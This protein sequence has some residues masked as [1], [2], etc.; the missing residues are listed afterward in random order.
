MKYS[1]PGTVFL[2]NLFAAFVLVASGC[3]GQNVN[4]QELLNRPIEETG[5]FHQSKKYI[6]RGMTVVYLTG[7]PYEIGFAH[8]KLCKDEIRDV[9]QYYWE[10]YGKLK[11]T[12]DGKWLLLSRSL[13]RYIPQEYVLEMKGIADGSPYQ[14]IISTSDKSSGI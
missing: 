3:G 7:T 4:V 1:R 10:A 9:H 12:P 6:K 8:G 11:N 14:K 2:S 13:E 5:R